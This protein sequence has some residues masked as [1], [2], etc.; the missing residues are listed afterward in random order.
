MN[1]EVDLEDKKTYLTAVAIALSPNAS[2]AH[3]PKGHH[4]LAPMTWFLKFNTRRVIMGPSQR[5]LTS[6]E[7]RCH[8][9]DF[10]PLLDDGL[11][12]ESGDGDSLL[13]NELD[14]AVACFS[15]IDV[16]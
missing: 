14:A 7:N 12:F 2:D 3:L 8:V 15:E 10:G 1:D 16:F 4:M 9:H 5:R 13:V 11:L 6:W